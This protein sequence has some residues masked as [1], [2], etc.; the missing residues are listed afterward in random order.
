MEAGVDVGVGLASPGRQRGR[1]RRPRLGHEA[2]WG[3]GSRRQAWWWSG[4]VVP[5]VIEEEEEWNRKRWREK[6]KKEGQAEI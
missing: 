6:K 4:R 2:G 3:C 1:R 5:G